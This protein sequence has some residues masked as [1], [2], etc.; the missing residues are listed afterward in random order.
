M[1]TTVVLFPIIA[2]LLSL[3]TAFLGHEQPWRAVN[4]QQEQFIERYGPCNKELAN[5]A[6]GEMKFKA[7]QNVNE[8]NKFLTENKFTIQLEPT[9]DSVY[10]AAIMDILL[11]WAVPG[12]ES[13]IRYSNIEAYPAVTMSAKKLTQDGKRGFCV[14]VDAGTGQSVVEVSA[15][16][17]D[18]DFFMGAAGDHPPVG[19]SLQNDR[20]AHFAAGGRRE[21]GEPQPAAERVH[22]R[23]FFPQG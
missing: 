16:N 6:P 2:S 9:P 18:R 1:S 20:H 22:S 23:F 3:E 13:K 10:V 21:P 7:S 17:G 5:F 15:N 14:F 8:V 12:T 19:V 4:E 11:K